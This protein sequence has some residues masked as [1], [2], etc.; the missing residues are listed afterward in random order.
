MEAWVT[1]LRKGLME[2]C[3]LNIL[4][5]GESYGYEIVQSLQSVDEL[6]VTESTVYPI[7][8]R[9]RKEG[10]LRAQVKPSQEGP[11]R[12][13]FSLTAL[14]RHRVAEMNAY[15]K[16]LQQAIAKLTRGRASREDTNENT[17]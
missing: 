10:Y 12:K 15:W 5:N 3:I 13:Y 1:Q 17:G 14:G 8:S 9:L 11:P 4:R 7:L 2:F 6:V 16:S